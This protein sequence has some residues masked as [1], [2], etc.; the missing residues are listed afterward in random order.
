MWSDGH[1]RQEELFNGDEVQ[2]G[3]I[4]RLMAQR[5]DE[6]GYWARW[7]KVS[8]TFHSILLAITLQLQSPRIQDLTSTDT[9]PNGSRKNRC[10]RRHSSDIR[11]AMMR[12]TT[13]IYKEI[14]QTIKEK[15]CD[16]IQQY[17]YKWDMCSGRAEGLNP[18]T[19]TT[20]TTRLEADWWPCKARAAVQWEKG[21]TSAD[22]EPYGSS[23]D[24]LGKMDVHTK[25]WVTSRE[26]TFPLLVEIKAIDTVIK[27][28]TLEFDP[29]S[30]HHMTSSKKQG[31]DIQ[32]DK[33]DNYEMPEEKSSR[34]FYGPWHKEYK[35]LQSIDKSSS[36]DAPM[37]AKGDAVS[38]LDIVQRHHKALGH[39][40]NV[41]D[42]QDMWDNTLL[43]QGT[44]NPSIYYRD[45]IEG[46]HAVINM[47]IAASVHR[48]IHMSSA[49]IAFDGIDIMDIRMFGPGDS[50]VIGDNNIL[51]NYTYIGNIAC[52]IVHF[53][54]N[55]QVFFITNGEPLYILEVTGLFDEC[56]QWL[57]SPKIQGQLGIYKG[58]QE[59]SKQLGFKNGK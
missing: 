49:S 38:V 26:K 14:Q 6:H 53:Q 24:V 27:Q 7:P 33:Y 13:K 59:L 52:F 58:V 4:L 16:M 18:A 37:L 39:M 28:A 15:L 51:F 22:V 29:Q 43:Q 55:E 46:T 23:Y 40:E 48:H 21:V 44:K 31:I 5:C 34:E 32:H 41:T 10:A 50:Q 35:P 42:K 36:D 47:A 8:F 11:A 54:V 57:L 45:S 1:M 56:E 2:G 9:E 19:A 12:G 3:Q 20:T 30:T 17:Y 25:V